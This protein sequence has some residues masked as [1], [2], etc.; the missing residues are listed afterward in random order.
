MSSTFVCDNAVLVASHF[1]LISSLGA[2]ARVVADAE[3]ATPPAAGT[4]AQRMQP[5]APPRSAFS[6]TALSVH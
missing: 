1:G 5:T 2:D 4:R 3:R 6:L